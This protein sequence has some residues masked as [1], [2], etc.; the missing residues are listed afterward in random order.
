M[1]GEYFISDHLPDGT[2]LP[3]GASFNNGIVCT[4]IDKGCGPCGGSGD[5]P[6][7]EGW[8]AR[9]AGTGKRIGQTYLVEE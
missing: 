6:L 8:C 9:C 1:P 5:H 7:K 2:R 4:V 3:A